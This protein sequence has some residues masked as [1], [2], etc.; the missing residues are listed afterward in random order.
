[1]AV[2]NQEGNFEKTEFQNVDINKAKPG[3]IYDAE[4]ITLLGKYSDEIATYRAKKVWKEILG[5]HF[6]LEDKKDYEIR[7][8][9]SIEHNQF[10]ISCCFTSACGRYA[11][12]RLINRQAPEAE[13]KLNGNRDKVHKI[14]KG[15]MA[16]NNK[17]ETTFVISSIEEQIL[18][19]KENKTLLGRLIHL[20]K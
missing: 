10:I 11:F 13:Q 20:F 16:D 5:S 14:N 19:N 3:L 2:H 17:N 1:M 9:C 15:F 8:Y 6:L 18:R 7:A 12:W 4:G